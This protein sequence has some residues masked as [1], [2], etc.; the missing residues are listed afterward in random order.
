MAEE[1][2]IFVEKVDCA[3]SG[4]SDAVLAAENIENVECRQVGANSLNMSIETGGLNFK[5]DT[6]IDNNAELLKLSGQLELA[7]EM[8]SR[9]QSR[10]E[11]A[12]VRIGQLEAEL[13]VLRQIGN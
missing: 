5:M 11:A 10:L 1:K 7:L 13:A 8:L 12:F 9:S 4:E 6:R 3:E 2:L